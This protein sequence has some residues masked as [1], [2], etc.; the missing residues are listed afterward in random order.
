M[1]KIHKVIVRLTV[2]VEKPMLVGLTL[3]TEIKSITLHYKKNKLSLVQRRCS[4]KYQ[5]YDTSQADGYK[6]TEK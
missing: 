3:R 5:H 1:I 6:R 4:E 2:K